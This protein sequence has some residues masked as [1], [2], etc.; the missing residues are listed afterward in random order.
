LKAEHVLPPPVGH[1]CA[2]SAAEGEV[3]VDPPEGEADPARSLSISSGHT[4]A[5]H[6]LL[7]KREGAAVGLGPARGVAIWGGSVVEREGL[8]R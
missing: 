3:E 2:A 8:A 7:R 4:H 6:S 5:C 1:Q